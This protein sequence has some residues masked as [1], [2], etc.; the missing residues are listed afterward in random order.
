MRSEEARTGLKSV[1][2]NPEMPYSVSIPMT[3][4]I[5]MEGRLQVL[6][7]VDALD[8]PALA[9]RVGHEGSDVDDPLA[10][11]ARDARPVVGV[12]RVRQ[13]L[14]LLELVA[15]GAQQVLLR[16]PLLALRQEP[17]DRRLFRPRDDVLDH[18][19]RVEVLEVQDLLVARLVG[20]LEEPV[21]VGGRVHALDGRLDHLADRPL[22]RLTVFAPDLVR[23][24]RHIGRQVLRDDLAGGVR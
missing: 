4:A 14:V 12:R 10:L 13:V 7:S 22:P 17:L 23:M 2:A 11:L 20:H 9:V 8:L 19:A 16:D 5:A 21:L 24:D 15:D 1:T 3:L 6:T 18:G